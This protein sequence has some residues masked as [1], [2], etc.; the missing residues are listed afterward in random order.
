MLPSSHILFNS[1]WIPPNSDKNKLTKL[2]RII[3]NFLFWED[4]AEHQN[5]LLGLNL[6]KMYLFKL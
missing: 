3:Y 5:D 1:A 4:R 6:L 2:Q